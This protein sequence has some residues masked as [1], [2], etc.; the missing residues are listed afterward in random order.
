MII[1]VEG[2]QQTSFECLN[3]SHNI[4]TSKIDLI[5]FFTQFKINSLSSHSDLENY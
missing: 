1:Q 5:M 3:F 4:G 2:S